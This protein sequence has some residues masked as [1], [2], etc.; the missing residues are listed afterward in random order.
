MKR[1]SLIIALL[2]LIFISCSKN[3]NS[4][5]QKPL[6]L[7]GKWTLIES[8]ADP[9]DGSGRWMTVDKANYYYI[10]FNTDNSLQGNIFNAIQYKIVNDSIVNLIIVNNATATRGYKIVDSYLTL[11]GGC[12]ES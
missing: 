11:T 3:S 1:S 4:T 7:I 6:T 12:I 5:A 10:Q 2:L 9:G 8:L